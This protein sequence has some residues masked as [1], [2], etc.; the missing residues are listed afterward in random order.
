MREQPGRSQRVGRTWSDSA[1]ASCLASV[2]TFTRAGGCPLTG[3]C[4]FNQTSLMT[5]GDKNLFAF[6][7]HLDSF[8]CEV[9]IESLAI[10]Y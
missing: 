2:F 3:H 8:F 1:S 6:V 7:G 10:S 9:L 5:N 4:R